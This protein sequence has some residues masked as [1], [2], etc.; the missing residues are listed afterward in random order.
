MNLQKI[1]MHNHV[2][3][4]K[5]ILRLDAQTTFVTPDELF[6]MHDQINVGKGLLLPMVNVECSYQMQSNDEAMELAETYPDRLAWFCNIDPRAARNSSD[7]DMSHLLQYY[8]SHGAKGVGEVCANLYFDDPMVLNLF[9]HCERCDMPVTFHIAP[10]IG[11]YY[12]LVDDYGLPRLEKI[13]AMFPKLRF[14]GHSQCFWSH[15]SAEVGEKDW[16][17]YPT[18]KVI[19]G[20]VVALMR[21]YP[22]LHG[23]MS[24]GSGFNAIT[25]D[26]DF[27]YAFL[28]EFQDRLFF[29]TDICAPENSKDKFFGFSFWLDEAVAQGK[30]SRQAY[31][32][33][34]YHNAAAVIE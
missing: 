8:K 28:E 23:D 18:G 16:M 30:I 9:K 26:P 15:I 33:I 34:C 2:V 21:K 6:A 7:T 10:Q 20:R 22:N 14:F 3:K 25:R 5:G 29:A 17:G 11:G 12:G 19:P 4:H 1:D 31:E 32:K 13:L 27:G 24:A